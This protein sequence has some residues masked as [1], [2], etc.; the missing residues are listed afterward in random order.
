[1][2]SQ[3]HWH[4]GT[5]MRKTHILALLWAAVL[6]VLPGTASLAQSPQ[7]P[8]TLPSN[9]LVGRLGAGQP[10]PAQAL[11]FSV[12]AAQ[13]DPNQN[14]TRDQIPTVTI[15]APTFIA[16]GY[17]SFGDPGAGAKYT[18]VGASCPNG[19]GAIKDASNKCYNLIIDNVVN[20]GWFG[21]YAT[22]NGETISSGDIS[23]NPQWRGTYTAGTTWDTVAV[24]EATYAALAAASTPGSIVWNS[25][26]NFNVSLNKFLNFPCA[27]GSSGSL[28]LGQGL[29]INQPLTLVGAEFVINFCGGQ[30]L[31]WNG[32]SSSSM[33]TW[34][35]GAYASINDMRINGNGSSPANYSTTSPVAPLMVLNYTGTHSGLATQ[36]IVFHRAKVLPGPNQG[37]IS[38]SPAGGGAQGSTITFDTSEFA[39]MGSDYGIEIGGGNAFNVDLFNSDFQGFVHNAINNLS[40]TANVYS[41]SFENQNLLGAFA[42]VLSQFTTFGADIA[43]QSGCCVSNVSKTQDV[44]SESDVGVNCLPGAFCNTENYALLATDANTWSA[45]APYLLGVVLGTGFSHQANAVGT[46]YHAFMVVDDSGNCAQTGCWPAMTAGSTSCVIQDSAASY[47][48]N[49]WAGFVLYGRAAFGNVEHHVI[50]S[51]TATSITL[52][53]GDCLSF[54]PTTANLYHIAGLTGGSAPNFDGASNGSFSTPLNTAGWG[55]TTTAGSNVVVSNQAT[56]ISNNQYVVIPNADCLG[57]APKWPAALIAKVT[58]VSGT[59]ITINRNACFNATDLPGYWGTSFTDNQIKYIDFEFNAMIGGLTNKNIYTPLGR[60]LNPG[61]LISYGAFRQD[62]LWPTQIL[63]IGVVNSFPSGDFNR[64]AYANLS[65]GYQFRALSQA[66]T[67][68]AT[69]DLTLAL[70]QGNDVTYTPSGNA[71]LNAPAPQAN[72]ASEFFLSIVTSGTTPYT[73]TFGSN[74]NSVPAFTTGAVSAVTT[75]FHFY[76]DGTNWNLVNHSSTLTANTT[77]TSGCT[78]GKILYSDGALLQCGPVVTDSSG[79][80]AAVSIYSSGFALQMMTFSSNTVTFK[81]TEQHP[82]AFETNPNDGIANF[83]LEA[84]GSGTDVF[85]TRAGAADWQWGNADAAAPVAQTQQVQSV[86]AGTSNT[87]GTDWTLVGSKGT[88]TGAGGKIVFKTAPAG[89]TGTAQNSA[90]N[91]ATIDSKGHVSFTTAAP[92]ANS[93]TGFALTTGSSDTAGRVTYS[94]ATTCSI[95][96]GAAYTNAPFCTITP[97]SAASTSEVT[98]TTGGLSVTFGTA[99]TAF[100]YNC[101]GL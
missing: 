84:A 83:G 10:G 79:D 72:T 49:Q 8:Q 34:D 5:R 36:S 99:Q 13:L 101:F 40:G 77:S 56:N 12:V 97:G 1:M 63:G 70:A 29:I 87:A 100:F 86:V 68:A 16:G 64:P 24:Q 28:G 60:I 78:A 92:T 62:Y 85:V 53:G 51:N 15:G 57:A 76:N 69:I 95:T 73:I 45:N 94:S 37:A 32:S 98:T 9:T 20:V 54:T 75:V 35:A 21:A 58:N 17:H 65:N 46:K 22:G 11:P 39:G 74:F 50:A 89:T 44:R 6:G 27:V 41:T 66:L 18:S 67:Q 90:T 25:S 31:I 23:A 43:H 47:T 30:Q 3:G 61:E 4:F 19:L 82:P 42:P 2:D 26:P 59:N 81:S 48:T 80:L 14:F 88:G 38:I 33:W 91:N 55:F 71:T 52:T 96:F 93:C 7:F